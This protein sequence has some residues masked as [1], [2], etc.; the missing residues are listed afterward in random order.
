MFISFYN[1]TVS[2]LVLLFSALFTSKCNVMYKFMK[3]IN[4]GSAEYF[5]LPNYTWK[6]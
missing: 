1:E 2:C 6:T 3:R 5:L 4:G